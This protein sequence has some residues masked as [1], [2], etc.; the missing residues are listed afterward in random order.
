MEYLEHNCYGG[1]LRALRGDVKGK[2]RASEDEAM[3]VDLA[4]EIARGDE[5]GMSRAG[6]G[7]AGAGAG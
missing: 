5:L 3:D 4:V 1:T 6:L 2:G 7:W